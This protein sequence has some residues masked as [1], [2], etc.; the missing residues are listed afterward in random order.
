MK[1]RAERYTFRK[2]RVRRKTLGYSGKPRLSI[3]RSL[4]HIYAQIID[5]LAGRT[6]VA[7]SSKEK[8]VAGSSGIKAATLVGELIG[9]KASAKGID[10][11]VFDRG[12]RPYHGRVK[13]VADGARSAGLKF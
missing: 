11:V 12:A 7:A 5:D 6:L 10:Q 4:K 9:K 13:A 3:Y 1:A 2:L 8:G